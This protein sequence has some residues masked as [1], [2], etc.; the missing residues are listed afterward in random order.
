MKVSE[1]WIRS[2]RLCCTLFYD[3]NSVYEGL[4]AEMRK[5]C[6]SLSMKQK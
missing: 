6:M 3:K 4:M 5:E 1:R 2:E